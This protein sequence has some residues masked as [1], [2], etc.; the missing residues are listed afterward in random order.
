MCSRIGP[1][2]APKIEMEK[3]FSVSEEIV[4]GNFI[5]SKDPR[6]QCDFYEKLYPCDTT[7][8]TR[9]IP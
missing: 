1:F 3:M 5:T 6:W 9:G 7:L 8:S 2:V 4:V